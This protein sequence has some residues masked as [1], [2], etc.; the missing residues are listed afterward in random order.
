LKNK[1]V[2]EIKIMSTL[3][4]IFTNCYTSKFILNETQLLYMRGEIDVIA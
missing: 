4:Y 1:F 2:N 3:I